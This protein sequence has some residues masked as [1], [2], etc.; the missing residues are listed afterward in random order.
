MYF[1]TTLH[2]ELCE[3][4]R[5]SGKT[6]VF[7]PNHG[8]SRP[9]HRVSLYTASQLLGGACDPLELDVRDEGDAEHQQ[10]Q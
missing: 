8:P 1:A 2:E 4:I 9:Q 6:C 7:K 10:A 3:E 5:V